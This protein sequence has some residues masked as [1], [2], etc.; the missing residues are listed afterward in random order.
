MTSLESQTP[1]ADGIRIDIRFLLRQVPSL[2]QVR[3][4]HRTW[5]DYGEKLVRELQ[6]PAPTVRTMTHMS[7]P[8]DASEWS[9][10]KQ[11][12]HA[13][14]ATRQPEYD[15]IRKR[16][17]NLQTTSTP[18]LLSTLGLWLAGA[19]GMSVSVTNPMVAVILLAVSEA[20][21]NW[22]ILND[23]LGKIQS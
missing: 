4:K 6:V 21:G 19:L 17:G 8:K 18:I 20:S 5:N 22:E 12:I 10:A 14:L 16:L 15:A 23:H 11:L 2:V 13:V 3:R 7:D 1:S 9:Y